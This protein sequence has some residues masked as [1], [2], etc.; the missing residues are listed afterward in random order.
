[1][2]KNVNNVLRCAPK[3]SAG[4]PKNF[5]WGAQVLL[6]KSPVSHQCVIVFMS[7]IFWLQICRY[8]ICFDVFEKSFCKAFVCITQ[9]QVCLKLGVFLF[10]AASLWR[11]RGEGGG[12]WGSQGHG[13]YLWVTSR[14]N[15]HGQQNVFGDCVAS[16]LSNDEATHWWGPM[17]FFWFWLLSILCMGIFAC[18][19]A[20]WRI[21]G[22]AFYDYATLFL[23]FSW[24]W[25]PPTHYLQRNFLLMCH[26]LLWG[27]CLRWNQKLPSSGR[28]LAS[29]QNKFL[30]AAFIIIFII[31]SNYC[32]NAQLK[33]QTILDLSSWFSIPNC[34]TAIDE[35][36]SYI[37][38]KCQVH[39]GAINRI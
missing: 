29:L 38:M 23:F 16:V 8:I 17:A 18:C 6:I 19:V 20:I 9:P 7:R 3:F 10:T 14:S 37:D 34:V 21:W 11:R 32:K 36:S 22:Q 28:G 33:S 30:M 26:V 4:A 25:N 39:T 24:L 27:S 12:H 15:L 2:G 35:P 31:C 1:M 5:Q 13:G